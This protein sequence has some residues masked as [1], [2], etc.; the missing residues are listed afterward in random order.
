MT[1]DQAA[2]AN[3]QYQSDTRKW[4]AEQRRHTASREPRRPPKR[5]DPP[6]ILTTVHIRR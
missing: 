4:A 1:F 5:P 6:R 2:A 3:D